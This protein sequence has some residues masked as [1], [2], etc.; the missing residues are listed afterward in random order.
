[1][2]RNF[3]IF[4]L[5]I[6]LV[7]ILLPGCYTQFASRERNY[8]HKNN[9]S[10]N[11][12]T[13]EQYDDQ[14]SLSYSNEYDNS[15]PVSNYYYEGFYSP[16]RYYSHYYPSY[17]FSLSYGHM[18]DPF[19]GDPWWAS[20]YYY[21]PCMI[22]NPYWTVY[23]FGWGGG[24][25]Y[26]QHSYGSGWKN[27]D[28]YRSVRPTGEN[29]IRNGGGRSSSIAGRDL[30]RLSSANRSR[31]IGAVSGL[32]QRDV[33]GVPA[34]I[35]GGFIKSSRAATTKIDA[36]RNQT[37]RNSC[38]NRVDVESGTRNPSGVIGKTNPTYVDP[39]RGT[40]TGVNPGRV[41]RQTPSKRGQDAV[42]AASNRRNSSVNDSRSKNQGNTRISKPERANRPRVDQPR[43]NA[44]GNRSN[45]GSVS[46]PQNNSGGRSSSSTP[47]ANTGNNNNTRGSDSKPRNQ[48]R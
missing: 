24:F 34:R 14:D 5:F 7:I 39:S 1:M 25:V 36:S 15:P 27:H 4:V 45:S 47:K 3:K 23:S 2:K 44:G 42:D 13:N 17:G 9:S 29:E 28:R 22:Y 43:N 37:S 32:R 40:R 19:W 21:Q 6:G 8:A 10:Y 26:N 18:Y 12:S 48:G 35:N 41:D 16:R 33:G 46:R 30:V 38:A 20:D 31:N 11:D